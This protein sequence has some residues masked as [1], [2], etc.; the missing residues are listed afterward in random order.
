MNGH[1]SRAA[2]RFSILL[3][4]SLLIFVGLLAG[5]LASSASALVRP[6]MTLQ[7]LTGNAD[8][9]LKGTVTKVRTAMGSWPGVAHQIPLTHV[10]ISVEEAMKGSQAL[11]KVEF[12]IPGGEVPGVARVEVSDTAEVF[13]GER[14]LVFLARQ[15]KTDYYIVYGWSHGLFQV[16]RRASGEEVLKSEINLNVADG[17]SLR[18][19]REVVRFTTATP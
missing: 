9:V 10:E 8:L 6:D 13:E 7:T 3:G 18:R 14:V 12:V 15:E 2:W 19:V 1:T 11:R 5:F 4:T 16:E 17:F